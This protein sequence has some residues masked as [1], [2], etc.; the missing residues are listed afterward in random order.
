MSFPSLQ[1]ATESQKNRS[2]A[3]RAHYRPPQSASRTSRDVL[4]LQLLNNHNDN[5][6]EQPPNFRLALPLYTY[7]LRSLGWMLSRERNSGECFR[8]G[9]LA[10]AIS[11]G[12]TTI[13][14]ALMDHNRC[15]EGNV[16]QCLTNKK[17]IPSRATLI[18]VPPNLWHQWLQEIEKFLPSGSFSVIAATDGAQLRQH[19]LEQ[20][21]KTD[22]VIVSYRIFHGRAYAKLRYRLKH[23]YWYRI[24]ADEFHELIA[25]AVDA[26]HPFNEAKHQLCELESWSRW[27]LT[28]T[29]PLKTVSEVAVTATFF[30][31]RFDR[32][33]ES[34]AE[35]VRNMVRRN[36]EGVQ[37]PDVVQHVV[38]VLQTQHERALYLQRERQGATGLLEAASLHQSQSPSGDAKLKTAKQACEEVLQHRRRQT[39]IFEGKL[40][41]HSLSIEAY[42]RCCRRLLEKRNSV[43]VGYSWYFT[44]WYLGKVDALLCTREIHMKPD[45]QFSEAKHNASAIL[46]LAAK[47]AG[48]QEQIAEAVY[49][50]TV[51]SSNHVE[52]LRALERECDNEQATLSEMAQHFTE[53][54]L[55]ERSVAEV[56]ESYSCPICFEDVKSKDC[57]I[58][59]CAHVACLKCWEQCLKRDARCPLCRCSLRLCQVH[60]MIKTPAQD[61]QH[62]ESHGVQRLGLHMHRDASTEQFATFGT[63]VKCIVDTI[64]QIWVTQ[65][66]AKILV[67]CQWEPLRITIELAFRSLGIEHLALK[68]HEQERAS[69]VRRFYFANGPNSPKVMLL[70]MEVS[71]SG[72][73]LTMANHVILVQPTWHG[74]DG[75]SHEKSVDYEEQAVG[76]CWRTGQQRSVHIWRLCTLHTVEEEMVECHMRIWTERQRLA[77]VQVLTA[78]ARPPLL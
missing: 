33:V 31:V 15:P 11:Y 40:N 57:C 26:R 62:T 21:C 73:N 68:G 47:A 69:I 60:P 42:L 23:F 61:I 45:K 74:L 75:D 7:Q 71:P 48:D 16:N 78:R 12:K 76:R 5:A 51:D 18:I 10:D 1:S 56:E 24:I 52:L 20:L 30:Q 65:I 36:T 3:N 27:G 49:L 32:T 53:L 29:P 38:N 64:Q 77:G 28:S 67:F 54:L 14:L 2:L 4:N 6:A 37:R 44:K 35:F 72:L 39:K 43:A 59:P 58:A 13:T 19:S 41:E 25:S 46:A 8:G 34:C 9:I 55:F 66:D 50:R 17:L 63:K 70:S 22:A